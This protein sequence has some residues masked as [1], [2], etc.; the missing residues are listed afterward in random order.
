ME[1]IEDIFVKMMNLR[2][3]STGTEYVEQKF[4]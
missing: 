1:K 2:K 3:Y 4:Q